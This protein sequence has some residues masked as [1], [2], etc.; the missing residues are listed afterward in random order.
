MLVLLGLSWL[1]FVMIYTERFL[2]PFKVLENWLT[3]WHRLYDP[4]VSPGIEGRLEHMRV[5]LG[6]SVLVANMGISRS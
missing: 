3:P 2:P 4:N 6:Q 5:L 1:F